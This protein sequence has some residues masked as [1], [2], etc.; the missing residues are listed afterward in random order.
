VVHTGSSNRTDYIFFLKHV[1]VITVGPC[2]NSLTGHSKCLLWTP[3]KI[4]GMWGR[5]PCKNP[6]WTSLQQKTGTLRT[7]ISAISQEV[8][9]SHHC[10]VHAKTNAIH[11]WRKQIC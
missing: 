1:A 5:K 6:C 8:V 3:S 10:S 11:G 2:R 4:W 7:F 9:A